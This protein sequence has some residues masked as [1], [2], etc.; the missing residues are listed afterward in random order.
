MFLIILGIY[1][2]QGASWVGTTPYRMYE[3]VNHSQMKQEQFEFQKPCPQE[4]AQAK[5]AQS[6]SKTGA[7]P[8]YVLEQ[9]RDRLAQSQRHTQHWKTIYQPTHKSFVGCRAAPQL[10]A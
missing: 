1:S 7:P 9:Q 8:P 2:K 3:S 5:V 4:S 6:L 10:G